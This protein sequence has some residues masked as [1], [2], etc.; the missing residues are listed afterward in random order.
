MS[1]KTYCK[2]W[3]AVEDV[4]P[5][6]S[7]NF[8]SGYLLSLTVSSVILALG[9][10]SLKRK[11]LRGL[12]K[13]AGVALNR[14]GKTSKEIDRKTFHV[15]GLLVPLCYQIGLTCGIP[16]LQAAKIFWAIT[17][18]G[19]T[20]DVMRVHVPIVQ[21]N[22][23]L[24]SILREN[25]INNVSGGTYFSLG[26]SLS[27]YFFPPV[28]AMTSIIFL[29]LGDMGAALVGRSFGRSIVNMGIGPGGKKS[30]EGS[31]A[32][33]LVCVI[34]GCLIFSQVHLREYAVVIASLTATLVELYEPFGINDNITIPVLSSMALL[35]GF[36]RTYACEPARNPLLW[37]DSSFLTGR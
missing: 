32:M 10:A 25:E 2:E 12:L 1:P 4:A 20:M 18:T 19:V 36:T 30:V 27:I 31:A 23:P 16:Q 13:D 29:V 35:F 24:K 17:I 8:I 14:I 11:T 15:M 37:W 5:L 6:P 3:A 21:R 22:W 34:S 28:I 33:F 26:C 7:A 9:V